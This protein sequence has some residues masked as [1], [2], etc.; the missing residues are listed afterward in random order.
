VRAWSSSNP[1]GTLTRQWYPDAVDLRSA[2]PANV[3]V[4]IN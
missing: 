1:S 4:S 3:Q 2:S